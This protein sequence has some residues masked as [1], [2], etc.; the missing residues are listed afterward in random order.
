MTM[1]AGCGN[2]D[3]ASAGETNTVASADAEKSSETE[4]AEVNADESSGANMSATEAA[5]ET[6]EAAETTAAE[7]FEATHGNGICSE[8]FKHGYGRADRRV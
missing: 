8:K 4:G 5:E 1:F 7:P 3:Q 6:S 2:K